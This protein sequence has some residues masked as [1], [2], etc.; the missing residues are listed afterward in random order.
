MTDGVLPSMG[1]GQTAASHKEK[2]PAG[3]ST[4]K[5]KKNM[6]NCSVM[7]YDGS[8]LSVLSVSHGSD[9]AHMHTPSEK[10]N[11]HAARLI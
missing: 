2:R 7:K 3:E 6:L 11:P 9:Q 4:R 5:S 8:A 10:T 1:E